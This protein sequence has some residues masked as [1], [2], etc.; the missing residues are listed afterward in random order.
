M[1]VHPNPLAFILLLLGFFLFGIALSFHGGF[2]VPDRH[3]G[4][5]GMITSPAHLGMCALLSSD[6][7]AHSDANPWPTVLPDRYHIARELY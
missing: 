3:G 2:A 6:R 5:N 1:P 7:M 4:L